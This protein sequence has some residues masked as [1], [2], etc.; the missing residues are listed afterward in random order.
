MAGGMTIDGLDDLVD[1]AEAFPVTFDQAAQLVA[2][3]AGRRVQ[4]RAQQIL[5]SRVRGNPVDITVTPDPAHR[6]TLVEADFAP[7][8]PTNIHLWLEHGTAERAHKAG[9]RTG[10]VPALHYM[11][12]GMDAAR[13]F[14]N[15]ID[16]VLQATLTQVF[17]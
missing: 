8:Q 14:P 2:D 1:G 3:A 16:G 9:R 6:Q 17:G 4:T 10:Q 12:G 15:E 11:R 13:S 7:G 5:R